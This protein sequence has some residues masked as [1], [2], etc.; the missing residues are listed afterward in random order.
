MQTEKQIKADAVSEF[1]NGMIGALES[2]FIDSPSCNL[3]Q[4]HRVAQNH[5]KDQY[6]IEVPNLVDQWGKDTAKLCGLNN[7]I[8]HSSG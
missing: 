5:I 8:Q 1:V 6:G 7:T 2:G 3:A 4:I